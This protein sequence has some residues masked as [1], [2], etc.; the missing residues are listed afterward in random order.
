MWFTAELM[1][2]LD[3]FKGIFQAEGFYNSFYTRCYAGKKLLG[4]KAAFG[5]GA[6]FCLH[7]LLRAA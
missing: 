3:N 5:G 7:W 4:P 1:V 2:G 6:A